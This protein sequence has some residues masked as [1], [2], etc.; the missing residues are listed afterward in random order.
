MAEANTSKW[1]NGEKSLANLSKLRFCI[2]KYLP[3]YIFAPFHSCQPYWEHARFRLYEFVLAALLHVVVL[4]G[5]WLCFKF[6]YKSLKQSFF[7]Q[8][9]HNQVMIAQLTDRYGWGACRGV[10]P[11]DWFLMLFTQSVLWRF[12]KHPPTP[13]SLWRS[14]KMIRTT[15]TTATRQF[16]TVVYSTGTAAIMFIFRVLDVTDYT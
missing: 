4:R 2:V 13:Y 14:S 11:Y 16:T 15:H 1:E 6:S 12:D 5:L 9:D 8:L 3:I 10:I 7:S